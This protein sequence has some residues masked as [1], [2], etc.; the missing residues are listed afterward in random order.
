MRACSKEDSV[1]NPGVQQA[2][3]IGNTSILGVAGNFDLELGFVAHLGL[4]C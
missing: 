2:Y 1:T 3:P 4:S